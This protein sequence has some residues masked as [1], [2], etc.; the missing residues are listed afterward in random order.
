MNCR[1]FAR[2]AVL[3]P[4]LATACVPTDPGSATTE[5]KTPTSAAAATTEVKAPTSA[6][7]TTT[8]VT[9]SSSTTETTT[10]SQDPLVHERP[11]GS[12]IGT[13]YG[14]TDRPAGVPLPFHIGPIAI[15]ALDLE[16][17][18]QLP[19]YYHEANAEGGFEPTKYVLV[20]DRN[21][22][23]PVSVSIA[24]DDRSSARMA[25]D[26][27]ESLPTLEGADHTVLFGVCDADDAQYNG[28]FVIAT[29]ICLTLNVTDLGRP[30]EPV[31]TQS[32]PFGVPLD[33]CN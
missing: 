30:E 5:V 16:W 13:G 25:Y 3:V 12:R 21:A 27:S 9:V 31:S 33:E 28:G 7:P 6:A 18:S 2:M 10:P 11:C 23:G 8:T 24:V 26:L 32:I 20:V 4:I 17:T 15:L 1:E 19:A 29:P 14:P 22:I